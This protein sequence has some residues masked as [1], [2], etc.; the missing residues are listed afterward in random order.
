MLERSQWKQNRE[1]HTT[2]RT[3]EQNQA[4]GRAH[5][6]RYER[7]STGRL[8]RNT[9]K[10]GGQQN[11]GCNG[12]HPHG[13][14]LTHKTIRADTKRAE[15]TCTSTPGQ[16]HPWARK[17]V[18][19]GGGSGD[20][21]APLQQPQRTTQDNTGNMTGH[22]HRSMQSR[23]V[24]STLEQSRR[25]PH[26]NQKKDIKSTASPLT[27]AGGR[28]GSSRRGGEPRDGTRRAR[29]NPQKMGQH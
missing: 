28:A 4:S 11:R 25:P 16:P 2:G 20:R 12:N 8:R 1:P 5:L 13:H 19:A 15:G 29:I 24:K 22:P 6:P 3:P 27:E 21:P 9:E 23:S 10:A 26:A 17:Q 18:E 14:N 7:S